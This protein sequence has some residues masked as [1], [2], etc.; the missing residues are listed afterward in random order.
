MPRLRCHQVHRGMVA[1]TSATRPPLLLCCR[2]GARR[3]WSL[4]A[5][6]S[7]SSR[8]LHSASRG[9]R[10]KCSV[11]VQH[12]GSIPTKL[13]QAWRSECPGAHRHGRPL[14]RTRQHLLAEMRQLQRW[15]SPWATQAAGLQGRDLQQSPWQQPCPHRGSSQA[16]TACLAPHPACHHPGSS[17]SRRSSSKRRQVCSS[18]TV[19]WQVRCSSHGACLRRPHLVLLLA[20]GPACPHHPCHSMARQSGLAWRLPPRGPC[21]HR[22]QHRRRTG[23]H[24]PWQPLA[25]HQPALPGCIRCMGRL[26]PPQQALACHCRF[27]RRQATA[28]LRC[29]CSTPGQQERELSGQVIM[30]RPCPH[31]RCCHPTAPSWGLCLRPP[32]CWRLG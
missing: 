10:P 29:R 8:R 12:G 20:G 28:C 11:V 25:A 32:A 19:V 21:P 5:S 4:E 30:C 16:A 18:S 13:C 7:S 9:L 2:R 27:L 26:Q 22:L 17:S 14:M 23:R 24:R 31:C 3:R 15:K 6:P 1:C